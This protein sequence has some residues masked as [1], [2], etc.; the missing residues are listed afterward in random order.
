MKTT[1]KSCLIDQLTGRTPSPVSEPDIQPEKGK[2][3]MEDLIKQLTR[4]REE[5][6]VQANTSQYFDGIAE[7]LSIA[8]AI[9]KKG[10]DIC[11]QKDTQKEGG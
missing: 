8:I 9:I 6:L 1:G 11:G 5:A 10:V 2:G 7:G 4:E 3:I